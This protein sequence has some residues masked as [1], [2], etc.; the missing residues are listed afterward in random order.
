MRCAEPDDALIVKVYANKWRWKQAKEV[1]VYRLLAQHNV[2]PAPAILRVESAGGLLEHAFTVMTLLP[3]QPLSEI[4]P[5]SMTL[6]TAKST[7]N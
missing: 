5:N 6:R 3:G 1:H 4:S 7:D 2:G